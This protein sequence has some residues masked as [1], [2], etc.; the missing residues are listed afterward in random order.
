MPQ[1]AE[2]EIAEK[3]NTKSVI[4]GRSR[5]AENQARYRARLGAT[6]KRGRPRTKTLGR[7]KATPLT[8]PPVPA[9]EKMSDERYLQHKTAH[10][11]AVEE[12]WLRMKPR[13]TFTA[14]IK[15]H[16]MDGC[17]LHAETSRRLR[18]LPVAT[19][20]KAAGPVVLRE[21]A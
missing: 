11:L 20:W 12:V 19:Q 18:V 3:S 16:I 17:T 5:Q 2:Y 1:I 6:S 9:T 4:A 13:P 15:R 14:F 21:A 8:A 7:P 10:W